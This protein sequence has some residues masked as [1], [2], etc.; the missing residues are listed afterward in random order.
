MARAHTRTGARARRRALR[1]A[2]GATMVEIL[3]SAFILAMLVV[4]MFNTLVSGRMLAAHRGE[5]RMAIGL[6]ERKVEQL[7]RAGYGA[8]G[9]D[10]DVSSVNLGSGTHPANPSIVLN[11]RG[12]EDAANDVLGSLTWS[13]IPVAWPSPGDSV[14]AKVVEVKMRWPLAAPRDSISITTLIG[15]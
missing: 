11:T 12:D 14:K 8:L 15:A 10:A 4:P 5:K 2:R 13:V 6:V 9:S 1:S 3:V 7:L